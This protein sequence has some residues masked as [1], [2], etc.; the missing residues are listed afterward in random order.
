MRFSKSAIKFGLKN[1][2]LFPTRDENV[3]AFSTHRDRLG[4][5]F[6]C[7]HALLE[8]GEM[9]LGQEQYVQTR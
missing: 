9:G 8:Y 1:W 3:A 5:I 4:Q 2:V 6:S 7:H